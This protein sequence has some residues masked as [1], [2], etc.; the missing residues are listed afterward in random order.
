MASYQ[1]HFITHS[2]E[3]VSARD[4][5]AETDESATK[6]AEAIRGLT[7]MELWSGDRQIKRWDPF[8]PDE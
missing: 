8:P 6:M 7:A 4:L 3:R 1:L 5:E 2:G